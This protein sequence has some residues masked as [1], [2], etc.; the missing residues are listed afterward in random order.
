MNNKSESRQGPAFRALV[1][2]LDETDG[3]HLSLIIIF[4][5]NN[6]SKIQPTSHL[7][8]RSKPRILNFRRYLFS[9]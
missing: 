9:R 6:H 4:S 2:G 3:K 8:N 1:R 5:Y 7:Y